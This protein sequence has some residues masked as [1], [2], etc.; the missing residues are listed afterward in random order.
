[1]SWSEFLGLESADEDQSAAG[2]VTEADSYL[3][4]VQQDI[5]DGDDPSGDLDDAGL[6]LG[7]ASDEELDAADLS[8]DT[9]DAEPVADVCAGGGDVW[10][11]AEDA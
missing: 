4:A 5:A 3:G 6:D 7:D 9:V 8:T 10:D 2:D 11:P 1:M